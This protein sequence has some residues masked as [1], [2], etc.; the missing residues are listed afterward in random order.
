MSGRRRSLDWT[1]GKDDAPSP[2]PLEELNPAA[3]A[4][5]LLAVVC[6]LGA[7][8]A[9]F[10]V[11]PFQTFATVLVLDLLLGPAAVVLGLAAHFQIKKATRQRGRAL[12]NVGIFLGLLDV[13][14][15]ALFV[16][17]VVEFYV[18]LAHCTV[19][20]PGA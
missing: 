6:P 20:C 1:S 7:A 3:V 14:A 17:L 11:R 4:S 8:W 18:Q 15:S 2:G 5:C 9:F 12:A 16:L 19:Q 13:V 10:V